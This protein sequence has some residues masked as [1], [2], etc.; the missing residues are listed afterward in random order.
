MTMSKKVISLLFTIILFTTSVFS[1][2]AE[3]ESAPDILTEIFVRQELF[4][5]YSLVYDTFSAAITLEDGNE[6]TGIGFTDYSAYYE[7]D[8]GSVGYFPAGFIADYGYEIPDTDI[9]LVIENLDFTDERYQFV[10]DCETVPFMEHCVRNGQYLKYGVNEHGAITYEANPYERGVCDESL[11]ALY[12][13]DT[14][15][16]V[17]DPDVGNY[18]RING[19]TLFD[20]IDFAAVEEQINQIIA[21]QNS[22]FS[23]QEIISA[24]HIAQ[25]AITSYLLSLQE[26]TFM[27]YKVT[28]LVES[29]SQLDPMQ[30]I[31]ITPEGFV[32]IDITDDI[33]G[34][35]DELTKW[36]VG[37]GCF[38]AIAG[39]IAL[40]IFVPAARP[41]SGAIIGAAVDVFMQVIVENKSLEN[42][43]WEKVAVAAVSGAALAWLCPLASSAVT[44][45]ATKAATQSLTKVFSEA[46]GQTFGKALGKLAGYGVQTLSSG[47]IIG[48][49]DY[50]DASIDGKDGWNAFLS[51]VKIGACCSIGV[52][53]LS[54]MIPLLGSS[55]IIKVLQQTKIGSK[56]NNAL[57]KVKMA[58]G[59]ADLW[60]RSK[61][62]HLPEQ[63]AN[64]ESILAPKS[65]HQ[66][67][68]TAMR[69]LNGQTGVM[70]GKYGE[71]TTPGD[72]SMHR[73]EMPSHDAYDKA[74]NIIDGKRGELPAIKMS[75]ADHRMTASCGNSV[76][77]IAYREKQA[78]LIAQGNMK[79]A[80]QMDIDDITSKFGTKYNDAIEEMLEY[81]KT[82]G[83]W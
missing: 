69:E 29:A 22:R 40:E 38:I 11:G 20:Q 37:A 41:L 28:D 6:I 67:A 57:S 15:K 68:E 18:V 55:K 9:G 59:K 7:A 33:P 76:E 14:N 64:L 23:Q 54:E 79:A 50:I 70:G 71:L 49:T 60:I 27:G 25:E 48:I 4:R 21:D 75:A 62:I 51:G 19:V 16:L 30:C 1:S 17:F 31:R 47:L 52:S 44:E 78:L 43:Q 61:Q 73:H 82:I 24:V 2:Y 5:Q 3:T 39:S 13:Y 77:A 56:I 26:E 12:S 74:Y 45:A 46:A 34:T 42:V 63:Y 81:A 58:I 65:I 35:A 8:D 83:G 32:I 72:G 80:I 10:Y 36:L 66:A 53:L